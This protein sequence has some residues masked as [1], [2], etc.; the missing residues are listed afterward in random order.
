MQVL[1]YVLA[2]AATVAFVVSIVNSVG[3]LIGRFDEQWLQ[4]LV[5]GWVLYA[6]AIG[7][8]FVGH[9]YG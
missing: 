7:V 1:F 8:G 9:L 5:A 6:A 3:L 4:P 2:A